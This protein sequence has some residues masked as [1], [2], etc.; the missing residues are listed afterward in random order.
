MTYYK[1]IYIYISNNF[2]EF[3][4]YIRGIKKHKFGFVS[5]VD[6]NEG[7]VQKLKRDCRIQQLVGV[8]DPL[9]A[10]TFC[11]LMLAHLII[12]GPGLFYPQVGQALPKCFVHSTNA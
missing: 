1:V 12:S 11:G 10:P 4:N 3:Q 7:K 8:G 5:K 2:Q 6:K 9:L